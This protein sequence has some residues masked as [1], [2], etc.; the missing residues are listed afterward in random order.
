[1][2]KKLIF[3]YLFFIVLLATNAAN[4]LAQVPVHEEPRHHTVFQNAAIRILDVR[5]PPGDTTLYHIHHTPSLFIDFT[6]SNTG[7]QLVGKE[8]TQSISK[9][10]GISFENLSAPNNRI[11]RVWN[12][13]KDTFHVM[14]IEFL[15]SAPNFTHYPLYQFRYRLAID[16]D[17]LRAYQFTLP[18]GKKFK[19]ME[20]HPEFILIAINESMIQLNENGKSHT[21]QIKPGTVFSKSKS[22]PFSITNSSHHGAD[23]VLL[24]IAPD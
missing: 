22:F 2:H 5:I 24:E 15:N 14:D 13:G 8:A 3:I 23:F 21:K 17:W 7:S 4:L 10:G 16:N 9:T 1:M 11:H 6:Q 19:P 20:G 12:N 18:T